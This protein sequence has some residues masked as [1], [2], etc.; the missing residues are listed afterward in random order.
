M[1][2]MSGLCADAVRELDRSMGPRACG[3][4]V[5]GRAAPG[6]RGLAGHESPHELTRRTLVAPVMRMMGYGEPSHDLDGMPFYNGTILATVPMNRPLDDALRQTVSFMR[7][8]GTSRG[9]A[10]DGFLW[11]LSERG[12]AGPRVVRV[13]DLRPYY[14]EALD[15][16]RFRAAVPENPAPA[17]EFLRAFGHGA[18]RAPP[19]RASLRRHASSARRS[20]E[21]AMPAMNP[22]YWSETTAPSGVAMMMPCCSMIFS[23]YLT[24]CL[25]IPV[26]SD[27]RMRPMGWFDLTA[28]SIT[29]WRSRSSSASFRESTGSLGSVRGGTLPA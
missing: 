15:L 5:S 10:T 13:A 4:V 24:R 7:C 12:P 27:R 17:I 3:A 2:P 9:V 26:I 8:H 14:V 21:S 20:T 6:F 16:A 19:L 18:S 23:E 22:P 1:N 29:M 11:V 25:G 28:S